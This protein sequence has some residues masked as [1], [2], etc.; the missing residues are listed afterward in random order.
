MAAATI[1]GPLPH[2]ARHHDRCGTGDRRG[3]GSVGA[4]AE[5]GPVGVAVHDLDVVRVTAQAHAATI[6]ANVVSCP[7]PWVWQETPS[8]AVPVGCTRRLGAVG[9]AQ[10]Q[11]VHV[12]A[13]ARR[14][15][16]R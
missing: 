8:T 2:L 16:P 4:Q 6:W 13:R 7:W 3:P 14:R 15:R 10:P 11:D 12:R 5:R 9:H 1:A